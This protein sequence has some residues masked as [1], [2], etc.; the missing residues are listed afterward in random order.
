MRL[1]GKTAVI[2]GGS[3][4][5]GLA[6]AEA[7]D[8]EGARLAIVA[9]SREKLDQ[10]ARVL[11]EQTILHPADVNEPTAL[12]EMVA[13]VTSKTGTPDILVN[14]QGT[15]VIKPTLDLTR[16][17]FAVVMRTNIESVTFA[18]IAFGRD[19]IA[20]GSGS[21]I[22]IASLSAHRGWPR[23][24]VYAMSKHAIIGLTKSLAAEWAPHGVRCNSISPGFFMTDLNRERMPEARK[25]A[26]LARTP[27]A[28]FGNV[29]E[30]AGAALYLASDESRFVSGTDINV[31]GGYLAAGI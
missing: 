24:T 6:L 30:L 2:I 9:R 27:Y 29:A 4:G 22:N 14:C 23:A 18:S 7:M 31:D 28:R 25:Q 17:E 1:K 11:S 20:R 26:A 3:G 16:E 12:D 19:M 13:S 10:A 15:T 21:I 8:R 5:I